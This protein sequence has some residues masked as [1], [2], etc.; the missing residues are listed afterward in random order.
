MFFDLLQRAPGIPEFQNEE[1]Q[2]HLISIGGRLG[3]YV[4]VFQDAVTQNGKPEPLPAI[5]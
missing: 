2:R 4:G 5:A 3:L 1:A